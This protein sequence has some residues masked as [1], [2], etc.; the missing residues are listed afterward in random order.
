MG[1]H[2]YLTIDILCVL[3]KLYS[4]SSFIYMS[5]FVELVDVNIGNLE[6]C[7][8]H[9]NFLSNVEVIFSSLF[10]RLER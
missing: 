4:I 2:Y 6:L 7:M 10:V 3:V 9:S 8:W 5:C 1:N